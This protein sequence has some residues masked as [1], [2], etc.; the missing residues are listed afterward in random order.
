[1]HYQATVKG[2]HLRTGWPV[3]TLRAYVQVFGVHFAKKK[4]RNRLSS[5][6]QNKAGKDEMEGSE[7]S[8]LWLEN[9]ILSKEKILQDKAS[10]VI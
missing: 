4:R 2:P 10:A 9:I 7:W 1:M 5:H 3:H 8:G 6:E